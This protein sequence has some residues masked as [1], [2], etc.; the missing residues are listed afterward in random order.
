MGNAPTDPTMARYHQFRVEA[1]R[2][3]GGKK[4]KSNDV[5]CGVSG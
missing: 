2:A 5:L 3:G 4:P 1:L